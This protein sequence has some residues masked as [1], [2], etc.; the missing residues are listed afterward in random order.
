[1]SY[2]NSVTSLMVESGMLYLTVQLVFVVL[3]ALNHPA[4]P[5]MVSIAVQIYVHICLSVLAPFFQ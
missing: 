3:F 1:M 2:I 5:I 4:Q